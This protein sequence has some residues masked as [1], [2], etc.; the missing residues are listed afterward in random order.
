[1]LKYLT[2]YEHAESSTWP[3]LNMLKYLTFYEDAQSSN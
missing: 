1:M 3:S 2:F